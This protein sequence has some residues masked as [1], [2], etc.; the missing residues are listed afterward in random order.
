M[1]P[2]S[3]VLETSDM[4]IMETAVCNKLPL[5]KSNEET[6]KVSFSHVE[7]RDY[8]IKLGNNPSCTSGP[9]V[10]LG[11]CYTIMASPM[12]IDAYEETRRGQRRD[13]SEMIMPSHYRKE[14]LM[15][16]GYSSRDIN[17]MMA[18]L[19]LEKK[20]M[21]KSTSGIKPLSKLMRIR[22]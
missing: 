7:L 6:A 4:P 5:S 17:E 2:R 14:K 21:N 22:R 8:E 12:N 1:A 20:K 15:E 19:T 16:F 3:T 11:W 18:K 13:R 9:P 10:E